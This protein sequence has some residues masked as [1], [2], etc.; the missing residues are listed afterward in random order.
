MGKTIG[1]VI[2]LKGKCIPMIAELK[3]IGCVKGI[4]RGLRSVVLDFCNRYRLCGIDE[5][6]ESDLG[7]E[8]THTIERLSNYTEH[9]LTFGN[10]AYNIKQGGTLLRQENFQ[11]TNSLQQYFYA[12]ANINNQSKQVSLHNKSVV[13]SVGV[14]QSIRNKIRNIKSEH[15]SIKNKSKTVKNVFYKVI[16]LSKAVSVVR[17]LSSVVKSNNIIRYL[18]PKHNALGTSY[19]GGGATLVGEYGPELVNLPRG[20]Q[21]LSNNQTQNALSNNSNITV[22]LN[23]AGN[24]LGNREFFDEMMQMMATELRTVLPA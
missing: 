24:V 12:G 2:S 11:K 10:K 23:V 16:G 17:P 3:K 7:S 19:F 21:I 1:V 13:S 5:L 8:T 15:R 14:V 20:S 18:A 22:N 6:M 9:T 4:F